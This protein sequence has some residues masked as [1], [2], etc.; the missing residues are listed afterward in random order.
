MFI[1]GQIYKRSIIHDS[2]GGNRQSGICPSAQAPYIFIFSG[3]GGTQHGYKDRWENKNVFSYTGE[4]QVGDMEF[5]KGNLALRDHIVSG[6]KVFL[7]EYVNKGMVE[8]ISEMEVINIGYFETHDR[9]GTLRIGIKFFFKRAGVTLY[10]TP[11]DLMPVTKVTEIDKSYETLKPNTTERKGLVTSRVGQGAYR[12]SILHRW[13]YQCA[14]TGFN[15]IKV[16]VASH[17]VP[18]RDSTDEERLDVDNGILLSA[19]YDALFDKHLISFENN[20]KIILSDTLRK[21][22]YT[23]LGVTGKEKIKDLS[24]GNR[25]YLDQHRERIA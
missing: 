7:F 13:E 1:K 12:M 21:Y 3:S 10:K 8:F 4:G 22:T 18:W 15:N 2:Y 9:K 25:K 5:T 20:G 11:S 16:L 19:D 14:A 23:K 24:E 17:I 6:K